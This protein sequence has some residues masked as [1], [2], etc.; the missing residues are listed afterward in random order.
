M[1][2]PEW[3]TFLTILA[4]GGVTFLGSWGVFLLRE[5]KRKAGFKRTLAFE[6][7]LNILTCEGV[8]PSLRER[9]ESGAFDSNVTKFA[10]LPLTR[11][12]FEAFRSDL[13]FLERDLL[14]KV[15]IFYHRLD[16]ANHSIGL[17][18]E[19]AIAGFARTAAATAIDFLE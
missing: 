8:G 19:V 9:V 11:V 7:E 17:T 14:Q 3:T 2:G 5:H 10:P 4:T 16:E 12:V 13:R 1:D 6:V 18:G 15:L